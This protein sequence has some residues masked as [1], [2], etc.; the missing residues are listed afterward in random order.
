MF[1]QYLLITR[2][3]TTN[4]F[5][6][7]ITTPRHMLKYYGMAECVIRY[8]SGKI[9][10]TKFRYGSCDEIVDTITLP[11][12][13]EVFDVELLGALFIIEKSSAEKI[14]DII[15]NT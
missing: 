12:G 1:G 7:I 2:D 9:V 4:R 10:L 8:A 15:F 3:T 14:A 11:F 6:C 5:K 13:I